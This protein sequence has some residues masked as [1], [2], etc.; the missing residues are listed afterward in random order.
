MNNLIKIIF[1]VL[2]STSLYASS[3][4]DKLKSIKSVTSKNKEQVFRVI[5][6]AGESLNKKFDKD[7][8]KELGRVFPLLH[9]VDSNYYI[10]ESFTKV[11]KTDSKRFEK[12]MKKH[13]PKKDFEILKD[14]IQMLLNEIKNGNG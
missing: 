7:V 1:L 8:L 14:N 5:N 4:L 13:L 2:F 11:L 10:L 9:K 3:S 6:T 12:E